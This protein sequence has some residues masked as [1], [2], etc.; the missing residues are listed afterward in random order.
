MQNEPDE[1]RKTRRMVEFFS[2]E[3][4]EA[5]RERGESEVLVMVSRGRRGAGF[6][7]MKPPKDAAAEMEIDAAEADGT[8]FRAVRAG[9]IAADFGQAGP[10]VSTPLASVSHI[11]PEGLAMLGEWKVITEVRET[12][13]NQDSISRSKFE[14]WSELANRHAPWLLG[15][16]GTLL[17]NYAFGVP[18]G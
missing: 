9:L 13:E 7:L 2:K 18:G 6:N 8:F 11:T 16:L 10:N 4:E 17:V 15:P 14:R 12:L 3:L 5:R 1:Y